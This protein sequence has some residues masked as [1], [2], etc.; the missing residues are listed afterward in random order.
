MSSLLSIVR[1]VESILG[2]APA[3][4]FAELSETAQD[5]CWDDLRERQDRLNRWWAYGDDP[6]QRPKRPRPRG[7]HRG[8]AGVPLD[9]RDPLRALPLAAAFEILLGQTVPR[10][11]MVRCPLPGHDDRTPSCRVGDELW[12]CFGCHAGGSLIDL[13]AEIY[14]LTPRGEPFFELRKRLALDLLAR[15]EAAA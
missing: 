1:G 5:E 11:G 13:G 4:L 3:E 8:H 15:E 7:R 12:H 2:L 14:G 9:H 6:R 10:S